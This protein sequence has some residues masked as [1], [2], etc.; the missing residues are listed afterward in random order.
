MKRSTA[1]NTW[2]VSSY[3][4]HVRLH[5]KDSKTYQVGCNNCGEQKEVTDT[6]DDDPATLK[7]FNGAIQ[8][9]LGMHI[10]CP[11]EAS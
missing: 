2:P 11:E 1:S 3:A 8:D 10:A 9:F 6:G 7:K 5:R 4:P